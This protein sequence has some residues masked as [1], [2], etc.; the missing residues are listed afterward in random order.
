MFGNTT[1]VSAVYCLRN[2]EIVCMQHHYCVL[3][4]TIS[5]QEN[6]ILLSYY[7]TSSGNSFPKFRKKNIGPTFRGPLKVQVL[8]TS[9]L[10]PEI[11]QDFFKIRL[12]IHSTLSYSG[13]NSVLLS[14]TRIFERNQEV[15]CHLY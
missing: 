2:T 4:V 6:C 1:L 5:V 9:R 10:K 14:A 8:S 11:V 3:K 13:N 7:A 12:N 15:I